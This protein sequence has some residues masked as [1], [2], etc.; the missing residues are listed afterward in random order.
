[1]MH[2]QQ[3]TTENLRIEEFKERSHTTGK[4][5]SS[6]VSLQVLSTRCI[7]VG[8]WGTFRDSAMCGDISFFGSQHT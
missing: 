6:P 4:R 7:S 3:L 8:P 1:M 5:A 2:G